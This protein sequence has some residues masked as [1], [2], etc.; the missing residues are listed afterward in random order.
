MTYYGK[1]KKFF[2]GV[3]LISLFIFG[4]LPIQAQ[5]IEPKITDILITNN[6]E[7]VLLYARLVNGFKPEMESAIF[8]GVPTVFTL[9]LEVY[10]VRSIFGIKK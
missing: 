3:I 8:A 2:Y 9:Q 7:N 10:K 6:A 5:A 1:N 4:G